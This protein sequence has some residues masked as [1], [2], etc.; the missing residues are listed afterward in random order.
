MNE[1]KEE[2]IR[3]YTP[4]F[5]YNAFTKDDIKEIE[6]VIDYAKGLIIFDKKIADQHETM[7][8]MK[9]AF[10]YLKALT[11]TFSNKENVTE[12][13]RNLMIKNYEELNP[14]YKELY[15]NYGIDYSI[16]RQSS[17]FKILKSTINTLD[18]IQKNMFDE[19]YY[20]SVN[21]LQKVTYTDAFINQQYNREFYRELVIFMTIQR[22]INKM[23]DNYFNI[24]TYDRRRL[25]NGFISNGMDYFDDVPLNYQRRIYKM[26]NTLISNKGTNNVFQHILDIF[27][28]KNL[29][30]YRYPLVKTK[31]SSG[32]EDIKF[33]K[34][35]IGD[36]L[37]VNKHLPIDFEYIVEKD[38]YWR[39]DKEHLFDYNF[40]HI[41]SKYLSI[42]VVIDLLTNNLQLAYF[43]SLLNH[44][45]IINNS[46]I[47]DYMEEN[48]CSYQEAFD[49]SGIQDVDF[50][51]INRNIS[52]KNIRVY[53][54]LIALIVLVLKRMGLTDKINRGNPSYLYAYNNLETNDDG[55]STEGIE[56]T[57]EILY[58]LKRYLYWNKRKFN[59]FDKKECISNFTKKY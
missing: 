27:S 11:N 21:Y 35:P 33:F 22:Y 5:K 17:D 44:C 58:E 57:N 15:Y 38:P 30:I 29:N 6:N 14:Y 46:K 16:S 55:N 23:M 10:N 7:A 3:K 48:K 9:N 41:E 49:K 37:N 51:F 52:T 31:N 8:S 39:T 25:K 12:F 53:N 56:S 13:E 47:A 26:L 24:D 54:A 2:M 28:F 18:K 19:M 50:S 1:F 43:F 36:I 4:Y 40:N 45:E 34:V 59:K 20:K 32:E 42:D